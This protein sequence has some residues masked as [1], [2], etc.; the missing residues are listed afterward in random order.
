[1]KSL[2]FVI[3]KFLNFLNTFE[4]FHN[5]LTFLKMPFWKKIQDYETIW[6]LVA[7]TYPEFVM[8]PSFFQISK[9]LYP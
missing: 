6:N 1:M 8:S 7:K 2:F 5:F 4:F 3:N 9:K